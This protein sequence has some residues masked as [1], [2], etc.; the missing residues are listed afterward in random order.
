MRRK[1]FK[2][3]LHVMVKGTCSEGCGCIS[4]A[5]VMVPGSGSDDEKKSLH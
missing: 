4:G 3:A 1:Q 5:P 2:K